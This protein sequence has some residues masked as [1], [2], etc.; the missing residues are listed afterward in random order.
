MTRLTLPSQAVFRDE[1][2]YD[3]QFTTVLNASAPLTTPN[4]I[5][6]HW[7]RLVSLSC[8][9]SLP[10][11]VLLV[12]SLFG[13]GRIHASLPGLTSDEADAFFGRSMAFRNPWLL[14]PALA[15]QGRMGGRRGYVGVHAR[16]GDGVFLRKA[17]ENMETAWRDLVGRL[18]VGSEEEER[19][20]E[21]VRPANAS[22]AF[23]KGLAKHARR[24]LAAAPFSEWAALDGEQ[25]EEE[26]SVVR[27]GIE[28][29][30]TIEVVPALESLVCR[31]AQHKDP[32]LQ[33]FNVPLYLA[34]D[35]RSPP[36]DPHLAIFFRSFPCTFILSDFDRPS[37]LNGGI[38]VDS[39][40]DMLKLVNKKDDIPLGRLFLPFLE[41]MIAAMGATTVGTRGSTF[42][43]AFLLARFLDG[44]LA[45]A[46]PRLQ[47]LRE[48]TCTM[49]TRWMRSCEGEETDTF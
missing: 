44:T 49:R 23:G 24:G 42:S 22:E 5:N 31:G 33:A 15:I 46:L 35:S 26:R 16:V 41:A 18:G 36:T 17:G 45:D 14:R 13:S 1:A 2:L 40:G 3:F 6:S 19:M 38:V 9:A 4:T 43:R 27:R 34:T 21:V 48:E 8:L 11:K 39:V 29:R 20:W 30:Q 32:S 37:D 28:E 25:E 10:H 7:R 12:G 47:S